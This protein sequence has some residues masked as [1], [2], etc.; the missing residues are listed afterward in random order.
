MVNERHLPPG[1]EIRGNRIRICF[2]WNRVRYREPYPFSASSPE[3]IRRAGK[4]Y[5]EIKA[6]IDLGIF[7]PEEFRRVFPHSKAFALGKNEIPFGQLAQEW[8]DTVEVTPNTKQEY[9]KIL[10]KYWMPL[11]ATRPISSVKY[12]ELRQL[13]AGICWSSAKT[14]NNALIPLRGVFS[15]AYED[16][17]IDRNPADRLKNRKHQKSPPDPF[18]REEAELIIEALYRKFS[19]AEAVHAAYFE[20]AFYTGMRT[21]EMLALTWAD[22]DFRRGYAR[23]CK[24]QSK[25]IL[26]DQTKTSKVRDV[27]LNERA[28]NALSI[29]RPLTFS[30]TGPI[31]ASAYTGTGF[32]TE[33]SQRV[34]FTSI[35]RELGI[36]HRP[37]YNTRHTYA[38]ILLMAGAN[39]AFVAAQLGHSVTMTLTVDSRWISGEADLRELAKLSF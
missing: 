2:R 6:K 32:K 34:I 5:S 24:A 36:R 39:P 7:S 31:F 15:V 1:I 14:L 20:F 22:I 38:T 9:R 29:C 13:V 26:N 25:G 19:P 4:L 27:A 11:L 30:S 35:L 33:K 8:L 28:L 3:N 18:T 10:N 17:V 16:E 21:S 23:V 12:S 37:A